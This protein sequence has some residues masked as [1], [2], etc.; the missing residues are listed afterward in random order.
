MDVQL[1]A[2]ETIVAVYDDEYSTGDKSIF[3]PAPLAAGLLSASF[4]R[5]VNL[6]YWYDSNP[7]GGGGMRF[8]T[9]ETRTVSIWFESVAVS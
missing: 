7:H 5:T 2:S 6:G 9:I 1:E 4:Q 8:N 3:L